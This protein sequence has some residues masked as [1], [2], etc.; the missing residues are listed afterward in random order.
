MRVKILKK[1]RKLAKKEYWLE[2]HKS[3]EYRYRLVSST[4]DEGCYIKSFS[5]YEEALYALAWRRRCWILDYV[6][7]HRIY[8]LD[9]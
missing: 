8:K 5:S 2:D 6:R 1:L 7:D 3:Y 4:C 9:V